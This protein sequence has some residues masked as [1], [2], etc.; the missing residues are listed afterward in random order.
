MLTVA[1]SDIVSL[2]STATVTLLSD[3]FIDTS[4]LLLDRTTAISLFVL[5]PSTVAAI[6]PRPI[7]VGDS[8]AT[9]FNT[10]SPVE[11]G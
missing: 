2:V 9:V 3:W 4:L 1:R 7:I 11:L 6:C 10:L 5:L 8:A